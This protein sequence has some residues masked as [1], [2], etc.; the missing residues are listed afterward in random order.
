MYITMLLEKLKLQA[1]SHCILCLFFIFGADTILF[2]FTYLLLISFW[3]FLSLIFLLIIT[4]IPVNNVPEFSMFLVLSTASWTL[5]QSYFFLDLIMG[6]ASVT[7]F[8]LATP[9]G[10]GGPVA[11]TLLLLT[12]VL[13]ASQN[14][15]G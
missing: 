11:S 5:L 15:S 8:F 7:I 1:S 13:L 10:S 3:L 2:Y 6:I 4:I 9:L 12:D 14:C